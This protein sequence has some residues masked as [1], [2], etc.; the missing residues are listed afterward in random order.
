MT[1]AQV[2][3][4]TGAAALLDGRPKHNGYRATV[5]MMPTG[6]AML[7]KKRGLPPPGGADRRVQ[8]AMQVGK[9]FGRGYYPSFTIA[10]LEVIILTNR[11][12]HLQKLL[13]LRSALQFCF[14]NLL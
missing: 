8:H 3:D 1:T 9:E 13:S 6:S 2:S 10:S 12:N 14:V 11:I 4:Y 7:M 5:V